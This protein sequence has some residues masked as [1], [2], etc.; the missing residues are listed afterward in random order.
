MQQKEPGMDV[1]VMC[2]DVSGRFPLYSMYTPE[3]RK[4][5]TTSLYQTW[6]QSRMQYMKV[7]QLI[8]KC[9]IY[10]PFPPLN[11]IKLPDHLGNGKPSPLSRLM[12]FMHSFI[13]FC[14]HVLCQEKKLDVESPWEKIKESCVG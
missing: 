6:G 11:K 3:E 5:A 14:L 7:L 10:T 4:S 8:L 2:S 12:S 13:Y 9:S 1:C